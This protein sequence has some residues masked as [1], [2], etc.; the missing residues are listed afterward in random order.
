MMF[1]G[2]YEEE[3]LNK[4]ESLTKHSH[5]MVV[6]STLELADIEIGTKVRWGKVVLYELKLLLNL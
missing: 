2:R 5:A 4:K 1:C 3:K 6:Y